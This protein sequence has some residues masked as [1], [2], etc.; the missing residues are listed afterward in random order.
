MSISN[1]IVKIFDA[2]AERLGVAI[3]WSSENII[4]YLEQLFDKYVKY[5]I[6]TSIVYLV[7]GVVLL[8]LGV[9][10]IK[11]TKKFMAKYH[12]IKRTNPFSEYNIAAVMTGV[13]VGVAF[14]VGTIVILVQCFDIVTCLTFPEKFILEELKNLIQNK[15]L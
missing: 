14:L 3:D 1:E 9:F 10:G 12:E 6:A 5:E 13:G 8:I 2:I 15:N 4:P 7:F 11:L